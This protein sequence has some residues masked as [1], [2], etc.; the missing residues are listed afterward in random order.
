MVT[1]TGK[2][3]D[4]GRL[5]HPGQKKPPLFRGGFSATMGDDGNP[6][7]RKC[8]ASAPPCLFSTSVRRLA[9]DGLL[10]NHANLVVQHLHESAAQGEPAPGAAAET[11]LAVTE[12]RHQQR[13]IG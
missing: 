11:Q 10:R 2:S 4:S 13:M 12:Q 6:N 8:V 7:Q 5:G 3:T 1:E 9:R